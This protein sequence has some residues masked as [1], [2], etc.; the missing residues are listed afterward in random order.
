[1]NNT[2]YMIDGNIILSNR[3][4]IPLTGGVLK[5]VM[6]SNDY[7]SFV[8]PM[9]ICDILLDHESYSTIDIGDTVNLSIRRFKDDQTAYD[10]LFINKKFII[11]DKEQIYTPSTDNENDT[12]T[13]N[14]LEFKIIIGIEEDLNLNKENIMGN[15][16]NTDL[17][18]ISLL[19]MNKIKNKKIHYEKADNTTLFNQIII[20]HGNIFN[21]LRY[22]DNYY[23][24]YHNGIKIFID[25]K[26]AYILSDFKNNI[27]NKKDIILHLNDGA[28]SI[29]ERT[30]SDNTIE[31]ISNEFTFNDIRK[32]KKKV[33]GNNNT[34]VF[35]NEE[36]KLVK[37]NDNKDDNENYHR[38]K[39][40]YQSSANVFSKDKIANED[41][42][43][44]AF[45][46]KDYDYELF[47][48]INNYVIS[49]KDKRFNNANFVL[50]K[51][52]NVFKRTNEN[53]Y[54]IEGQ[55]SLKMV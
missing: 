53:I 30:L 7:S 3:Q 11:L 46:C 9:M 21:T 26:D 43:Y 22:V 23:G 36:G 48:C 14:I 8:F 33:L 19:A 52:V 4:F 42:I 54:E 50:D 44:V 17:D 25:I 1:M 35:Q 5:N 2:R 10:N 47:N 20:P 18:S 16:L 13:D 15:Y 45:N 55:V 40:Y 12:D 37:I 32:I 41:T 51:I 24:M 34:Y 28:K 31:I 6:I 49:D 29:T 27:K 39:I 38:K